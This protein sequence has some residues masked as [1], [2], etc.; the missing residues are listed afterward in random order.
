M[1]FIGS[2]R[3]SG[4]QSED[5]LGNIIRQADLRL[6]RLEAAYS[7]PYNP[8]V[9][10]VAVATVADLPPEHRQGQMAYVVATGDVYTSEDGGVGMPRVWQPG[11]TL[12]TW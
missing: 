8:N 1:N 12:P 4:V 11:G 6:D 5:L 7:G 3:T 2:H 9:S 10:V